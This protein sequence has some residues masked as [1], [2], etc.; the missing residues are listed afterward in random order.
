MSSVT[1]TRRL[2]LTAALFAAALVFLLVTIITHSAV[3]LFLMW[4]PL[5]IVPIVLGK[6]DPDLPGPR[7]TEGPENGPPEAGSGAEAR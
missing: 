6:R 5:L 2:A 7:E 4:L 3:P 1:G